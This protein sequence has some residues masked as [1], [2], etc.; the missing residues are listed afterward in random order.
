MI[1][2]R[3]ILSLGLLVSV[4][5]VASVPRKQT[6]KPSV[7]KV[8]E[9]LRL[10]SNDRHRVL[11]EQ[12]DAVYDSLIQ[13]ARDDHHPMNLRWRAL[14]SAAVL[15]KDKAVPDL[16]KASKA[17]EWFM[18][19]ASLVGLSEFS[20]TKSAEVARRLVKDPALVVRSAAVDVLAKNGTVPDRDLLWKE[21]RASYNSRG[22]QS[23]WI[24]GQIVKAL[25]EKPRATEIAQFSNLLN[26]KDESMQL[27]SV[28]GLRKITGLSLGEGTNSKRTVQLWREHMRTPASAASRTITR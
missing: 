20:P 2:T 19:N 22:T 26:E 3:L 13:I 27:A 23:L 16:V 6:L 17:P 18:R 14:T 8:T 28:Q 25:A 11:S 15:R 4:G 24:R 7:E 10:P 12:P 1:R 21:L 9:I 5:A